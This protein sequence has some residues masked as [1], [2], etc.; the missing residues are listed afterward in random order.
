[1]GRGSFD[2]EEPVGNLKIRAVLAGLRRGGNGQYRFPALGVGG[3]LLVVGL[4]AAL[5][6][7]A[8]AVDG[9]TP[10]ELGDPID[11]AQVVPHGG[12]ST[13][14]SMCLQCHDVHFADGEYALMTQGSVTYV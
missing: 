4:S 8:A 12:Y 2:G 14:T 1:M 3:A 10:P 13:S 5:I 6:A 7:P 9:P 11:D